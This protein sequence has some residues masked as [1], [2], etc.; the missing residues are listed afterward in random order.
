MRSEA[1]QGLAPMLR[2]LQLWRPLD[3]AEQEAVLSLPH[4][5]VELPA[6]SFI[7][8]EEDRTNRSCLLISGF[9]F[10]Q[11]LAR[12]GAR[13]ILAL[14]MSGDIVDLQNSLLEIAD[15]SVQ[16]L[17]ATT[18]AFL[19]REPVIELAQRFPNIGLAMWYDT[20]VDGS[21]AREWIL[22]VGRRSGHVRIAHTIC[23]FGVRLESLGLGER[24]QY[25]FPLTQDQLADAVGLTPVHVNR[26]LRELEKSGLISRAG[27]SITVANWNALAR[28]GDFRDTYLHLQ[29]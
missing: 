19:P 11:K 4:E 2:K 1:G 28:A 9:A 8:R 22:N 10:R 3:P 24:T 13:S 29:H 20:L 18:V 15:H 23:E 6:H 12:D 27:R 21:I 26:M 5:I 14:H 25:E 7:V 16:T 17:T